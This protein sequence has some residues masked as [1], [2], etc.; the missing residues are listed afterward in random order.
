[1]IRF[2]PSSAPPR[3]QS[4]DSTPAR[5]SPDHGPELPIVREII[6]QPELARLVDELYFEYHFYFDGIDFGWGVTRPSNQDSVDEALE[7]MQK[8]RRLG[9]RSHF[10]I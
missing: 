8:L 3:T 4:T 7:L 1:M 10:W 9:I 5:L 6:K 2:P